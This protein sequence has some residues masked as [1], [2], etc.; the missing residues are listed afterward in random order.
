MNWKRSLCAGL[1]AALLAGALAGCTAPSDV[2]PTPQSTPAAD[3]IA[4]QAVGITRDTVLFTADGA[5]VTADDYLYWLL[6][7]IA[8]AKNSGYLADGTPVTSVSAVEPGSM[9][10]MASSQWLDYIVCYEAKGDT[11]EISVFHW[12]QVLSGEPIYT[13]TVWRG[14]AAS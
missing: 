8:M 1:A 10:P 7:A 12:Q 14:E 9:E 6:N 5:Q 4:Y 13:L 2:Q 11:E 3:D